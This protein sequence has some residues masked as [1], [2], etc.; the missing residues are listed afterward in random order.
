MFVRSRLQTVLLI[1]RLAEIQLLLEC[2]ERVA[3]MMVSRKL[4]KCCM[5]GLFRS[6]QWFIGIALDKL[7]RHNIESY[8]ALVLRRIFQP[9]EPEL[10]CPTDKCCSDKY[11]FLPLPIIT[12]GSKAKKDDSLKS[13]DKSIANQHH[14]INIDVLCAKLDNTRCSCINGTILTKI[15][16]IS[17]CLTEE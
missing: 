15:I 4:G 3:G 6:A 16:P 12:H 17:T 2:F 13:K 10:H 5:R 9:Q 7:T 11:P 14:S 1:D 8:S